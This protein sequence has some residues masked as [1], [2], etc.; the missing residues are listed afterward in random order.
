MVRVA[1]L[2]CVYH[3][4]I[5][6]LYTIVMAEPFI[7]QWEWGVRGWRGAASM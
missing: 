5:P 2:L 6:M 1:L 7:C 4:S 3:S